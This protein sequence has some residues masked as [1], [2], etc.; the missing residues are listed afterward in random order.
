[1]NGCVIFDLDGTLIDSM[2]DLSAAVNHTRSTEHLPPLTVKQ[3]SSYVGE[4]PYVLLQRAFA[5]LP[6]ADI[7]RLL[8]LYKEYYRNH[9]TDLTVRKG[10]ACPPLRGGNS[11]GDRH[12]QTRRGRPVPAGKAR[13][14]AI[15]PDHH[16]FRFRFSAQAGARRP[17]PYPVRAESRPGC[18]LD[19][20]RPFHRS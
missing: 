9:M 3:I 13:P 8:V 1:M 15:F 19:G 5:D 12:Q 16:R 18:K 20:G 14:D 10:R 17:A 2:G 6:G 7:D 4:G 11:A